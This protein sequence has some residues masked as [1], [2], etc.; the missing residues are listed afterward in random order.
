MTPFDFSW[1][2]IAT[3]ETIPDYQYVLRPVS[4]VGK[5]RVNKQPSLDAQPN[6]G[7]FQ[8]EEFALV[9]DDHQY[10]NLM[11]LL[12]GFT[13][14]SMMQKVRCSSLVTCFVSRLPD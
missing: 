8:F 1:S 5:V 4:G 3:Q 7:E 13:K 2:K 14:Y 10:A 11:M 12:A 6:K 9:L